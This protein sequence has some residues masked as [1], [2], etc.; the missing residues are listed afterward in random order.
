MHYLFWL[1]DE[2]EDDEQ[3]RLSLGHQV[4]VEVQK[5]SSVL[6]SGIVLL[7]ISSILKS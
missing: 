4:Y 1:T 6:K 2:H 3:G 7:V 5:I